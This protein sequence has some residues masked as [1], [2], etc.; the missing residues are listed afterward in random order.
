MIKITKIIDEDAALPFK[1]EWGL[2]LLIEAYGKRLIF[3][4][5]GSDRAV[6][7]AWLLSIDLAKIE[8]IILSHGHGDHTGGLLPVLQAAGEQIIYAHPTVWQE[9]YSRPGDNEQPQEAGI[10][11]TRK[12]IESSGGQLEDASRPV[13]I[14]SN[15]FVFGEIPMKTEMEN[16][17]PGLLTR[18]E[19]GFIVDHF[20]DEIA[21]G[22]YSKQGL[23]VITGCAHRGIINTLHRARDLSGIPG[24]YAVIGGSHLY[25]AS[26]KRISRTAQKLNDYGVRKLGLCHCTGQQ[27]AG[28]I[29]KQSGAETILTGV[30]QTAVL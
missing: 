30:G 10:P 18:Q 29:Q 28:L 20:P 6:I 12:E 15:I 14:N 16:L 9:R 1:G 3:D 17:E 23:I 11:Y 21:L 26:K 8:G 22:I 7:N 2:S 5:G 13:F 24:I 25:Q 4:T 19:N 27:A